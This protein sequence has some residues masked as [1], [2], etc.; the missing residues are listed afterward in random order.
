MQSSGKDIEMATSSRLMVMSIH[1]RYANSIMRGEKTVELRKTRP[2]VSAGQPVALYATSPTQAVVATCIIDRV[3][4]G[5]PRE[6][7][8]D[9]VPRASVTCDEYDAYFAGSTQAVALH[10]GEVVVLPHPI[11][12]GSIRTRRP[13]HPPQT[14]HF[15]TR[16]RLAQ[17]AANHA[18]LEDLMAA[19]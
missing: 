6:L 19:M 5:D 3:E 18:G 16:E 8:S 2:L 4:V 12:L 1:T 17:L 9:L 14:W 11:T 10:L 7:R 15:F 13:W